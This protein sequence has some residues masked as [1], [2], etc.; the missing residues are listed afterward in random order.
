MHGQK[1]VPTEIRAMFLWPLQQMPCMVPIHFNKISALHCTEVHTMSNLPGFNRTSA[2]CCNTSK[3]LIDA[4]YTGG[5]RCPHN[6]KIQGINI[7]GS[8]RPVDCPLHPIHC[9]PRVWVQ[10]LTM[11]GKWGGA[12]SCMNLHVLS[13]MKVHKFQ[14]YWQIIHQNDGTQTLVSLLGKTSGCKELIT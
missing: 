5:F 3:S 9:S 14:V 1:P 4:Q 10:V 11:W 7:K 13:M 2:G 12:P 8:C 6:K